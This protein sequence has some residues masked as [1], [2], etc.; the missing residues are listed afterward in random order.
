MEAARVHSFL[1]K[2]L[3]KCNI[4]SRPHGHPITC[5]PCTCHPRTWAYSQLAPRREVHNVAHL[6]GAAGLFSGAT[7]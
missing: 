3:S 6:A 4:R 7:L 2:Q 1:R 5:E